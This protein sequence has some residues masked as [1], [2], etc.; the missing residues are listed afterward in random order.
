M[1]TNGPASL[2]S[3]LVLNH[4]ADLR[5]EVLADDAVEVAVLRGGFVLDA[6]CQTNPLLLCITHEGPSASLSTCCI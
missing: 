5:Q 2:V 4:A 6:L 1:R 3:D